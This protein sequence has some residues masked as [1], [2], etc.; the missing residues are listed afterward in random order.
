MTKEPLAVTPASSD[1]KLD[2]MSRL[3]FGKIHTVE[4]NVKVKPVGK[5]TEESML[6]LLA[7]ARSS[8]KI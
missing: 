7:Y 3:N 2:P 5:V 4:H 8:L 1:Q 6:S